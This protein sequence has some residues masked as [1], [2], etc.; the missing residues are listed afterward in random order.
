MAEILKLDR[1]S[2][3]YGRVAAVT[4]VTLTVERGQT[5]AVL[6]PNGAG[7]TSLGRATMGLV[8][9]RGRIEVDGVDISRWGAARRA[10][11]GVAYAPSSGRV[12]PRLSVAQNI[13]VAARNARWAFSLI[14]EKFPILHEKLAQTAGELSGGQQQLLS[15]AR[16]LASQPSYLILDEPSA[17]LAPVLVEQIFDVLSGL[18][19]LE[20]GV[21][22]LEQ[23]AALG[24]SLAD[25]C[26]VLVGGEVRLAGEASELAGSS[27]L[28]ALYL[29]GS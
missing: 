12:F 13:Q 18:N 25:R 9:H 15:I 16:G 23:N 7:K 8:P 28:E 26:T 5:L 11:A 21:I 20:I 1:V 6:G 24:L 27:V 2:V 19:G 4:D 3:N 22:L 14:E 29:G 17:G 10:R